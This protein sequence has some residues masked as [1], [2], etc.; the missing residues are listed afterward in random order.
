MAMKKEYLSVDGEIFGE[1]TTG[2]D[3]LYTLSGKISQHFFG[4][5]AKSTY[6]MDAW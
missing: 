5:C 1:V 6:S 2:A 3:S 4:E